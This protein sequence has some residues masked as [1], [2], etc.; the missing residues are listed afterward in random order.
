MRHGA[1]IG[2]LFLLLS[3]TGFSQDRKDIIGLNYPI[4]LRGIRH[5]PFNQVTVIDNRFDTTKLKVLADGALPFHEII[6]AQPASTVIASYIHRAIARLPQTN[7]RLYIDLK[8]CRCGNI[9]TRLGGGQAN[10][11]PIKD[12]LFFSANAYFSTGTHQYKKVLSFKKAIVLKYKGISGD[13]HSPTVKRVLSDFITALCTVDMQAYTR[14]SAIYDEE[15][16]HTNVIADWA[17]YPINQQTPSANGVYFT[18]DDFLNNRLQV[19]DFSVRMECDSTYS[20]DIP[21]RV[22]IPWGA[23][24]EGVFYFG[25]NV[26]H[27]LLREGNLFFLPLVRRNNTFCFHL[28]NQLPNMYAMLSAESLPPTGYTLDNPGPGITNLYVAS[29]ALV[30]GVISQA[31]KNQVINK[32]QD[33]IASYGTSADLRQCFLDMDCGDVVF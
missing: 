17:T 1:I 7:R 33:K 28:P 15:S 11:A 21:T 3:M 5:V 4:K 13:I 19:V 10:N 24:Y 22:K 29:A 2:L 27:T 20:L 9:A 30:I 6:F 23:F 8:Q 16:I 25:L 32:R 18:F 12:C 31:V 26:P 14:D